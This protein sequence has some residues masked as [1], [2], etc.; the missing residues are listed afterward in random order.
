MSATIC[1]LLALAILSTAL[2]ITGHPWWALFWV[3]LIVGIEILVALERQA[4]RPKNHETRTSRARISMVQPMD[5]GAAD[6]LDDAITKL[7]VHMIAE[8]A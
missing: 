7:E 3:G 2:V 4:G 8:D 1:S 6:A 5:G